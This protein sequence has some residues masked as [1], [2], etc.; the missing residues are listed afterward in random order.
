[1]IGTRTSVFSF[2]FILQRVDSGTRY[3]K[4]LIL[5]SLKILEPYKG[6][7]AGTISSRQDLV[8]KKQIYDLLFFKGQGQVKIFLQKCKISN[9][10]EKSIIFLIQTGIE[11][12]RLQNSRCFSCRIPSFQT[13]QRMFPTGVHVHGFVSTSLMDTQPV[14]TEVASFCGGWVDVTEPSYGD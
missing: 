12:G 3:K 4:T 8:K 1:M 11:A 6:S 2:L 10:K 13:R 5:R 9:Y 14:F 7:T